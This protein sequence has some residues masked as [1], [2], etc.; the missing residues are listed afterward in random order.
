MEAAAALPTEAGGTEAQDASAP[1]QPTAAQ[2]AKHKAKIYGEEREYTTDELIKL[3]Q[4][5]A[6]AD[7]RFRTSAERD[8][9]RDA[10]L[11]KIKED[12]D[13]LFSDLELDPDDWAEKR[14][15]KKLQFE[16]MSDDAKKAHR[17]EQ[18]LA[19]I[20]AEADRAKEDAE[21]AKK[22]LEER[23]FEGLKSKYADELDTQLS[24]AFKSTGKTATPRRIAR[25]VEFMLAHAEEHGEILSVEKAIEKSENEIRIDVREIL[26]K[27]SP[28]ELAEVLPR[29]SRDGLRQQDLEELKRQNPLRK[30]QDRTSTAPAA[31]SQGRKFRGSSDDF[32]DRLTSKYK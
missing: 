15:L 8:K 14:L 29:G 24:D 19:R 4:K 30:N 28:E 23:E 26:A 27:M 3:A 2:I 22:T 11:K 6:A 20:K 1:A 17:A 10:W 9:A 13:S 16:S 31:K 32:F 21:K 5:A 18:E 12:P 7:E 25:A